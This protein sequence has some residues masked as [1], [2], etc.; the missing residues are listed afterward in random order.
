MI[1]I[2]ELEFAYVGSDFQLRVPQLAVENGSKTSIIGPSGS[3]K[4]TL[5]NL[6]AGIS[7]MPPF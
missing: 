1:R 5:L 6:I 2:N 4:T 7:I 3:G